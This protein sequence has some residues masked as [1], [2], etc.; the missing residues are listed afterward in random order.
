M[1]GNPYRCKLVY[2]FNVISTFLHWL[3]AFTNK[4]FIIN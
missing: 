3:C 2:N 4:S 1:R